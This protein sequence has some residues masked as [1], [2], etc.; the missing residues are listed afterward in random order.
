MNQE[1]YQFIQ[2]KYGNLIYTIAQRISGDN[3]TSEVE[4]NVQDLWLSAMDAIRWFESQDNGK[5]G[6]FEDFKESKGFDQYIKTCLWHRK[7]KKGTAITKKMKINNAYSIDGNIN[8]NDDILTLDIPDMKCT[9]YV[10]NYSILENI[11]LKLSPQ[12]RIVISHILEHPDCVK[13]NGL[14]NVLGITNATKLQT[15][16]VN[17]ALREIRNQYNLSLL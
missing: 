9:N 16:V 6:K 1:Q 12:H 5:N 8:E 17:A 3:A 10:Y 14:V 2:E 4:D 13:D 7:G 15:N 11:S